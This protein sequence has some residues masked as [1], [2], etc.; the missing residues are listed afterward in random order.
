MID[1]AEQ[2]ADTLWRALYSVAGAAT[3]APEETTRTG[4]AH[5][6]NRAA[7]AAWMIESNIKIKG[8]WG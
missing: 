2:Q 4:A 6:N 3:G 5:A 7:L 8:V 1:A